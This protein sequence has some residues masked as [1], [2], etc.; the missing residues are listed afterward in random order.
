[1]A[2]NK[3]DESTKKFTE[4]AGKTAKAIAIGGWKMYLLGLLFVAL[5]VTGYATASWFWITMPFWIGPAVGLLI[6]LGLMLF[7]CLILLAGGIAILLD[8]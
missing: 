7:A 4:Q 8:R 1:M 3:L 6:L 5:K 2:D